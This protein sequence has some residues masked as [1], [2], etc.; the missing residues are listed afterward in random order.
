MSDILPDVMAVEGG[1][2]S[3][4]TALTLLEC[5]EASEELG[6]SSI[7][8]RLGIAKSTAHRLTTTLCARGFVE[9]NPLT[10]QYRLGLRVYELGTLM[11]RRIKLRQAAITVLEELRERTR[12]TVQLAVPD[13][14]ETVY[15]ERLQ[16]MGGLQLFLPIGMRLPAHA[17]SCGRALAAFDPKLAQARRVAG[18][19]PLTS[20]TIN[21]VAA[22]DNELRVI[23]QQGYATSLNTIVVGLSSVAAPIFDRQG[24]AFAA[25][26][27]GGVTRQIEP[28]TE[29]IARLVIHASRVISTRVM[30]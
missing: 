12:S 4:T 23:R 29:R 27:V 3:V 14:A 9:R 2:K 28:N 22:F 15:L 17:T 24:R 11:A 1:V 30:V 18:F 20:Q 19:T 8:R 25:L 21:S 16:S 6:I 26:S 7:A 13:G 10:G 5:F